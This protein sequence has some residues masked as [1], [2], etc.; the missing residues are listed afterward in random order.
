[1]TDLEK[2]LIDACLRGAQTERETAAVMSER[3]TPEFKARILAID[4]EQELL[5]TKRNQWYEELRALMGG[6]TGDSLMN[7][8]RAIRG[9]S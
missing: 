7:V 4:A 6:V 9:E 5:S 3:L 1:M 2:Q 8:A